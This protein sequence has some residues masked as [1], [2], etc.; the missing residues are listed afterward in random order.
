[1]P[2]P[3]PEH[4]HDISRDELIELVDELASQFSK[5]VDQLQKSIE[6]VATQTV[7]NGRLL[8]ALSDIRVAAGGSNMT[9]AQLVQCIQT[10]R[11]RAAQ[12]TQPEVTR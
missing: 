8:R 6:M 10:L 12:M 1:M 9:H 5:T 11:Q 7:E 3:K 2:A 4:F